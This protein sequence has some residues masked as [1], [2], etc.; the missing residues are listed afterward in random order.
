MQKLKIV[1]A[2]CFLLGTSCLSGKLHAQ[3][4]VELVPTVISSGG[5]FGTGTLS[6]TGPISLS[7][8]VGECI[9]TTLQPAST[10][11]SVKALTQGFQQPTSTTSTLSI[12]VISANSSCISASNGSVMLNPVTSTGPVQYAWNGGSFGTTN[13]FQNLAPGMYYYQI[14]DGNFT[15]NDSVLIS[16]D[17]VDC[18]EQLVFWNGITPNADGYNDTWVIDGITNFS[19]NNV[20]IYSRWGDLVWKGDNYDNTLVVWDGKNNKSG[21]ELP[22][23]TYFYVVTAGGKTYKGWVELTH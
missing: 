20:S 6:S 4:V 13:L 11:F 19:E 7:Y 12:N 15:I 17:A 14:T 3:A 9:V 8:T 22:D 10:P 5:G 23:A 18:G 2:V 16:E 1:L 21:K